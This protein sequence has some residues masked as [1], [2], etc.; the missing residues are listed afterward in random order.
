MANLPSSSPVT[1]ALRLN[2][3]DAIGEIT[4]MLEE[5]WSVW[6]SWAAVAALAMMFGFME[7]A[8]LRLGQ[9]MPIGVAL[10]QVMPYWVLVACVM[11]LIVVVGRRF[12]IWRHLLKP[13]VFGLA[14][15]AGAFA[16]LALAGRALVATI[17]PQRGAAAQPTPLQLFQTY[18]PLDLLTY[19]AFVGTLY[20]FLYYRE[21]RRRELTASRLQASIAEAQLRG[22]EAQVDPDLLFNTLNDISAL[23]S[24]GQQKPVVDMLWRLSELLRASLSDE[25]PEEIPLARELDLL[26]G[27]MSVGESA[28]MRQLEISR[29]IAADVRAALVPRMILSPLIESAVTHC[30]VEAGDRRRVTISA[31]RVNDRLRIGLA[32]LPHGL[33]SQEE[34]EQPFLSVR[35]R[36]QQLY[37]RD[38]SVE[39]GASSLDA[40]ASVIITIPFRQALASEER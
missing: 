3:A 2:I 34:D 28:S 37:G 31:V 25:R 5:P 24:K 19:A 12:R 1:A 35:A 32:G 15:T 29:D 33:R 38:Q 36:L 10:V 14:A 7:A 16:S 9:G 40:G 4:P 26:D 39:L 20:A 6:K 23:A 27:R 13:N 18:F 22:L 11:P 17:D 8:Q 21:A 30:I